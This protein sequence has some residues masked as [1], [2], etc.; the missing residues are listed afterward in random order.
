MGNVGEAGGKERWGA[1]RAAHRENELSLCSSFSFL[2]PFRF[3][4]QENEVPP[5]DGRELVALRG[6]AGRRRDN[7]RFWFVISYI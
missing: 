3:G 6:S 7:S 5:H 4:E 2:S 1:G